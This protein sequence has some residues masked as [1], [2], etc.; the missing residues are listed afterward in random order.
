VFDA[1]RGADPR[2]L[3]TVG[4]PDRLTPPPASVE[5]WKVGI[6]R[7]AF[8]GQGARCES[9]LAELE[10]LG[11]E[12]VDVDLPEYPLDA[13]MIV[14]T[15]EAGAAF[16]AFSAGGDD[17][18]MVRQERFAWPNTF[19]HASLIPAVDYIRANRLRTL[20]IRDLE[21]ALAGVRAIVHPSFASGLLPATNLGGQPTVVAPCGFADDGTPFSISFTGRLHADA[22]VLA[23]AM[24][25]QTVSAHHTRHPD[26]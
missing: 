8:E 24:A 18:A 16:D 2:D 19:R 7:G 14:L 11:V 17:D 21:E 13:M 6:P 5:G 23:L 15:A 1:I 9:V 20:L 10:Q 4:V 3:S 26:F 25:W 22:D 12:L